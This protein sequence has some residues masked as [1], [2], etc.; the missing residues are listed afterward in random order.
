MESQKNLL[1][2]KFN[3]L[4]KLET[5]NHNK[6]SN[7]NNSF[8]LT[9]KHHSSLSKINTTHTMK[10]KVHRNSNEK[11]FTDIN[12]LAF[13]TLSDAA[14]NVKNLL[15]DFLVNAD[16]EDKQTYHIED[17]LKKINKK[18]NPINIFTLTGE[19]NS[20]KENDEK[21]IFRKK[22]YAN[23]Y[24]KL[25]FDNY[26]GN[27]FKKMKTRDKINNRIKNFSLDEN[28]IDLNKVGLL[29]KHNL[30]NK[31]ILENKKK[32]YHRNSM[33]I[34]DKTFYTQKGDKRKNSNL[35]SND[36]RIKK[37]KIKFLDIQNTE[38]KLK[39]KNTINNYSY[40]LLSSSSE[41]EEL[42]EEK[43]ENKIKMM[44]L[45]NK[46]SFDKQNLSKKRYSYVSN[47]K[48][49]KKKKTNTNT[50]KNTKIL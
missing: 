1:S 2:V 32:A 21:I 28:D 12:T 43:D 7:S 19:Q 14:L 33:P 23:H 31:S 11:K 24:N 10:T 46:L 20:D 27:Y 38:K 37:P 49:I 15:S 5:Y 18:K 30:T 48:I 34:F 22:T 50:Y 4:K 17:E 29:I 26:D 8:S 40:N 6:P 16:P 47:D 35:S 41:E 42:N 25:K 9:K 36:V 45:R 44:E 39:K 3:I 13:Q